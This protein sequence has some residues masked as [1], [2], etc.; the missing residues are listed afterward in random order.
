MRAVPRTRRGRAAAAT[1][2]VLLVVAAAVGV[3]L[4]RTYGL[5]G[6]AAAPPVALPPSPAGSAAAPVD[7]LQGRWEVADVAEDAAGGRVPSSGFV[8]YRV[9]EPSL[10]REVVGRTGDVDGAVDVQAEGDALVLR[11]AVVTADLRGLR[12]DAAR[13]R[14]RPAGAAARDRRLPRRP[15]R[16]RRTGGPGG[17]ADALAEG[18]DVEVPGVLTVRE[19]EVAVV[20]ELTVRALDGRVD[21]VGSAPVTLSDFGVERPPVSALVDDGAL[22]LGLVLRPG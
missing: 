9:Q 19:R 16:R 13:A 10:N 2:V 22:E 17:D 7:A 14:R 8:G 4:A 6:G 12:S 3:V 20:A 11:S 18:V 21:V 1:T 15:L 5:V